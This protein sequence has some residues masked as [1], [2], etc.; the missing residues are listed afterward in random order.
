MITSS[1][2][3]EAL[4]RLSNGIA[5]L[6]SSPAWSTWLRMQA[7]FHQYSFSNSLLI[8]LQ[9]SSA[10]RVAG[11]QTWRRLGR[12]VRRGELAIWI[13]APVT[14]RV[15]AESDA[16]SSETTKRVVVTFRPVPVFDLDQTEGEPLPE[17][18]SRLTGDDPMGVYAGLVTVAESIGFTVEDHVFD[19]ETNGDWSQSLRRIRVEVNLAPAHPVKTLVHELGHALLHV[20]IA[21]RALK[22]LEAESIAYVVCHAIGIESDDWS[23][24]YVADWAGGGDQAIAAIKTAGARIQ[25][26]AEQILL[27]LDVAEL[28]LEEPAAGGEQ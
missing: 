9:R 14:R 4:E 7:R 13:L 28:H 1:R 23:F 19:G 25:Q 16:E 5:Q 26:T 12:V 17:V 11:F 27:G 2:K 3:E 24:G 10:T 8:L 6:T 15:A 22:E 18:C 20:D 21:N